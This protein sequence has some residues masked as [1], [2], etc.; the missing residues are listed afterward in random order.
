MINENGIFR[1]C[2]EN[3][4]SKIKF[5][6][7]SLSKKF[8]EKKHLSVE[9]I[10]VFRSEFNLVNKNERVRSPKGLFTVAENDP[11]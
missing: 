10:V 11:K 4:I 9:K 6:E 8:L 3:Q 1:N 5:L 7:K 2:Y